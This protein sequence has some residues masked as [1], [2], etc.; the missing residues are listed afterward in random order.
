MDSDSI[1]TALDY[2]SISNFTTRSDCKGLK[3]SS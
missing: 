1:T 3:G 2:N